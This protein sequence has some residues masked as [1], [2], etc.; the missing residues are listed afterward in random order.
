MRELSAYD[1]GADPEAVFP[2]ELGDSEAGRYLARDRDVDLGSALVAARSSPVPS[3][4]V[5]HGPSTS[6]ARCSKR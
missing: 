3:M 2:E 1:L 6:P 4:V 5:L